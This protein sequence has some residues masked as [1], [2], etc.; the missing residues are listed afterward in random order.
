MRTQRF[1]VI[2]PRLSDLHGIPELGRNIDLLGLAKAVVAMLAERQ[3]REMDNV[4]GPRALAI[5]ECA[6]I[7]HNIAV[8]TSK[9][10]PQAVIPPHLGQPQRR[11]FMHV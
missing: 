5:A 7:W 10:A 8:E 6:R 3:L 11:A 4:D 1:V 2:G 9:Y